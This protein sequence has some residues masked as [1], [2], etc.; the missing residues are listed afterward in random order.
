MTTPEEARAEPLSRL[1]KLSKAF[2]DAVDRFT[3]TADIKEIQSVAVEM[4]ELSDET[5]IVVGA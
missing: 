1:M 5:A 3:K 4:K 2:Q